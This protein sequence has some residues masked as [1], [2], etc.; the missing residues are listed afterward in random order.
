MKKIAPT[1]PPRPSKAAELI[2]RRFD[3]LKEEKE[4]RNSP[5]T[6]PISKLNSSNEKHEIFILNDTIPNDPKLTEK[7]ALLLDVK[8]SLCPNHT[9]KSTIYHKSNEE[10]ELLTPNRTKSLTLKKKNSILA[11]RR[12]I[13]LKA[14]EFSDI[15]GM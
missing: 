14:L 4:N 15:Q 12:K 8:S 9:Q 6:P 1:P 10:S 2:Q 7:A 11:K 5:E 13:S 3:I